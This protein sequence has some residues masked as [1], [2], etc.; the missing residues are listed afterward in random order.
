MTAE[1][2]QL[3]QE[4]EDRRRTSNINFTVT[5]ALPGGRQIT[6]ATTYWPGPGKSPN[7]LIDEL[8][9][10]MDR[11]RAKYEI[12]IHDDE[13]DTINSQIL[14]H[15]EQLAQADADIKRLDDETEEKINDLKSK[16]LEAAKRY[17]ATFARL[18]E[19]KT[20]DGRPLNPNKP[21]IKHQLQPHIIE[22]AK[23]MEEIE[24]LQES[25]RIGH[26]NHA[27]NMAL[28][29]EK[30]QKFKDKKAARLKFLGQ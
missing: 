27:A 26:K 19:E 5:F 3:P 4:T 13:E 18:Q 16:H 20:E 29:R 7:E 6:A 17:E 12:G 23:A 22:Q 14:V 9:D 30:L 11:Q 15:E 1:V 10:A 2:H 28:F 24:R 25:Q 21:Q 8:S